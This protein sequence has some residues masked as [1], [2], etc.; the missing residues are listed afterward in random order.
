MRFIGNK[1]NLVENIYNIIKTREI[2]GKRFFD[3]FSGTTSVGRYFKKRGYQTISSDLLYF[4]YC[5]QRA[6]LVNNQQ[7][8]FS[9]LLKKYDFPANTL[10][11]E[12]LSLVIEFLNSLPGVE[13]FVYKNYTPEGS[14]TLPRPRMFFIGENGKK[15]DAIRQQ[16]ENWKI[17]KLISEDEYFILLACLIET[18]PFYANIAG[19]YA[20]FQK[21]WDP[22]ALKSLRLREIEI[23]ESQNEHFAF[24]EDSVGLVGQFA[25]DILYLD[26]PYNHR[27]YAPNYHLLETVARYDEPEI[28][29]LVGIRSYENQ[30][31]KFCNAR[32]AIEELDRVAKEGKFK[33]L[34]L[35][36]NSEGVMPQEEILQTLRNY[37]PTELVEF[38]Y[39]RFKSN[40]NGEAKHKKYIKEQL[41]ILTSS[42]N[43]ANS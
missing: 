38:D 39:L 24:S 34:I 1:E 10:F 16:I 40:N 25:T 23:F 8:I 3:V 28:R 9:S 19:V 4:S 14:A 36:Y 21:T 30:K 41:Y 42:N 11:A 31:S 5:L 27:Q 37:G 20:A 33:H 35:S 26:P 29:G 18:V 43:L 15:I 2:K 6:Y 7:P 13:G 32:T 12:P 17:E 22:R